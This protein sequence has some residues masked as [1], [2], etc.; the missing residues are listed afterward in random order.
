MGHRKRLP[1]M[2]LVF[3]VGM[4]QPILT[5]SI[6]PRGITV[7]GAA[8]APDNATS[9]YAT[10]EQV[11]GAPKSKAGCVRASCLYMWGDPDYPSR[12]WYS[13]PNDEEAW[14]ESTNGGY[15]DVDVNDGYNLIGALNYFSTMVLIKGNSLHRM[16]NFPGDTNFGVVPLIPDL[17]GVATNTCINDGEIIIV[18][19]KRRMGGD[20]FDSKIRGHTEVS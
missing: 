11:D 13:G 15:L 2:V 4:L 19:V 3:W 20:V 8:G 7:S 9:V 16:D 12:I 14:D 18:P 6:T 17:G 10:Y 1:I 5:P